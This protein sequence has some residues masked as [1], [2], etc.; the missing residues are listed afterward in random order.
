[1]NLLQKNLFEILHWFHQFCVKKS[2]KY[3]ICYGTFLGAVRHQGFIPWDDDIDVCMPRPDYEQCKSIFEGAGNR[4]GKYL[5]ETPYMDAAD[6]LYTFNKLYDTT[7]TLEE[8]LRVNCRR[9]TYLDIFPLDGVGNTEE[10]AIAHQKRI[11]RYNM[12]L[13]TRVCAPRKKRA[14]YKNIAI[15]LSRLIPSI[16][17]DEKKLSRRIDQLYQEKAYDTCSYICDFAGPY[18]SKAIMK[19]ELFGNPTLYEFEGVQLY[20]PEDYKGYLTHIY[21]DWR[22]LPP[23]E[24]RGIQHDFVY[25]NLNKSYYFTED[26]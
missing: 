7:T 8:R 10:E 20:G 15:F 1:M 24:K 18:R 22:T 12:F 9:G 26:G 3:Y 5:L 6:Y 25:L 21:G 2:L 4:I 13:M 14:M 16:I 17:V 23:V 19:K 11:D